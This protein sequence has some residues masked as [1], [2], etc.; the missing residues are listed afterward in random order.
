M[1]MGW[2]T[3]EGMVCWIERRTDEGSFPKMGGCET[4][5][6]KSY[7]MY[8]SSKIFITVLSPTFSEL[9]TLVPSSFANNNHNYVVAD[10]FRFRNHY[11]S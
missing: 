1:V 5:S 3:S 10:G 2:E 7:C 4:I 6:K 9:Y 8:I 11:S